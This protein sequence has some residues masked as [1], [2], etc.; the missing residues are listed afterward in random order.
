MEQLVQELLHNTVAV[1]HSVSCLTLH[2][3]LPL[4]LVS[5]LIRDL[6]SVQLV[7]GGDSPGASSSFL[8]NLMF[9]ISYQRLKRRETTGLPFLIPK[10][11]ECWI[12]L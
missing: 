7:Y 4:L 6:P 8:K 10:S 9:I 2:P 5:L 12:L 11:I 3:A 1:I